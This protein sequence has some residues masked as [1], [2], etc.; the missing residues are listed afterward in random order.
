[1]ILCLVRCNRLLVLKSL[2]YQKSWLKGI[3]MAFYYL[4][5]QD[6]T[7]PPAQNKITHLNWH[8]NSLLCLVMHCDVDPKELGK[9][10]GS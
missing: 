4:L 2:C 5:P 9:L 3:I 7:V 6:T 1:M 8:R 10:T